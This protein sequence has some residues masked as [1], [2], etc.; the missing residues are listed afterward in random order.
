MEIELQFNSVVVQADA[1][2]ENYPMTVS[3]LGEFLPTQ[4]THRRRYRRKKKTV[5]MLIDRLIE[6]L[7]MGGLL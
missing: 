5:S 4:K 3:S 7:E 2:W 6:E 1:M